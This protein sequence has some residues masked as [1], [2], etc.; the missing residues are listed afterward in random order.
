VNLKAFT[1]EFIQDGGTPDGS[2]DAGQ[3]DGGFDAGK[4]SG[5]TDAGYD[6]GMAD[7]GHDGGMPYDS[8]LYDASVDANV[9]DSGIDSGIDSGVDSGFDGACERKACSD[10]YKRCKGDIIQTCSQDNCSW[11][12]GTVCQ[13]GCYYGTCNQ[14]NSPDG[15]IVTDAGVKDDGVEDAEVADGGNEPPPVGCSCS[16]MQY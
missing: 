4:D 7:S 9:Q 10:G 14:P 6:S 13:Y 8:G 12:N 1:D 16:V 5:M 3:K 11:V 15:G 2:T